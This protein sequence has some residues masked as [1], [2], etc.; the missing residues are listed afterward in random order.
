MPRRDQCHRCVGRSVLRGEGEEARKGER[1][2]RLQ[3]RGQGRHSKKDSARLEASPRAR[4]ACWRRLT[5]HRTTPVVPGDR[6]GLAVAPP[7]RGLVAGALSPL[8]SCSR[9]SEQCIFTAASRVCLADP[10]V[11]NRCSNSSAAFVIITKAILIITFAIL[12]LF[13]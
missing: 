13:S 4:A 6:R 10:L 1:V 2:F 5:T 9:R 3:C 11:Q 7:A 8:C 12:S